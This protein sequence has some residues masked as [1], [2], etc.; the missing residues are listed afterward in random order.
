[1]RVS[2]PLSVQLNVRKHDASGRAG[3]R[4]RQSCDAQP[5]PAGPAG[6]GAQGSAAGRW[7]ATRAWPRPAQLRQRPALCRCRLACALR[8]AA[9]RCAGPRHPA[10]PCAASNLKQLLSV[11]ALLLAPSSGKCIRRH[12][13]ECAAGRCSTPGEPGEL[14]PWCRRSRGFVWRAAPVVRCTAGAMLAQ[15]WREAEL[16]AAAAAACT[17]PFGSAYL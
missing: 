4:T 8:C 12:A 2:R 17:L 1:M 10:G 9:L 16:A 3:Q 15:S 11:D 14:P 5:G 6:S 7:V 13:A